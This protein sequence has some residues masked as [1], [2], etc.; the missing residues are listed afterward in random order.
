MEAAK[1][2]VPFPKAFST[3]PL[4]TD[5]P[6]ALAA[7]KVKSQVPV[8]LLLS[9]PSLAVAVLAKSLMLRTIIL[10]VPENVPGKSITL[11]ATLLLLIVREISPSKII[12]ALK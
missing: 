1:F 8:K 10:F 2:I 11:P 6:P 4:I 12:G 5:E 9:P 3:N 7:A